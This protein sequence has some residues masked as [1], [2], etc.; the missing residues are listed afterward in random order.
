LQGVGGGSGRA[1]TGLILGWSKNHFTKLHHEI[2]N[3]WIYVEGE[4]QYPQPVKVS[5]MLVYFPS[6]PKF[7][8]AVYD[9]IKDKLRSKRVAYPFMVMGDFN[10]TLQVGDIKGRQKS[11]RGM[12]AFREWVSMLQLRHIPLIN[13]PETF[14]CYSKIAASWIDRVFVKG[15][16]FPDLIVKALHR[17]TSDHRPLLIELSK[18]RQAPVC[19]VT[20]Y[21]I[22]Y[23]F[24]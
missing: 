24:D 19:P 23:L 16:Y 3:R 15:N 12:T 22:I 4:V 7:R 21:F 8:K 9:A 14:T 10:E 2:D 1:S 11:G 5:I 17:T 6:E 18:D 13:D 20:L